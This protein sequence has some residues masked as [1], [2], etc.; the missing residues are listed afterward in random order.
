MGIFRPIFEPFP[1]STADHQPLPPIEEIDEIVTNFPDLAGLTEFVQDFQV[2]VLRGL[3]NVGI[4]V[5]DWQRDASFA[6]F[7][8]IERNIAVAEAQ[9][10][11]DALAA[12]VRIGGVGLDIESTIRE[13]EAKQLD[14]LD[15]DH[16][17][18]TNVIGSV[19]TSIQEDID[20]VSNGLLDFL[21]GLDRRLADS[22]TGL[23][24][25]TVELGNTLVTKIDAGLQETLGF[26]DDTV[27][28]PVAALLES[29]PVQV[30]SLSDAITGGLGGLLDIPEALLGGLGEIFDGLAQRLG[31]TE[32]LELFQFV[33]RIISQINKQF[34]DSTNL[35]VR[36]GSWDFQENAVNHM[37]A[38]L[39]SVPVIG[40]FYSTIHVGEFENIRQASFQWYRPSQ[41]DLGSIM[42]YMRR[43]P[44]DWDSVRSGLERAGLSDEKIGQ[45]ERIVYHPL[46]V[47]DVL[48]LWHRGELSPTGA[49]ERLQESG[50]SPQDIEFALILSDRIPPIQDQILFAVRGVFDVEESRRFGEFEGLP[51][52][53]EQRF[54]D[55]FGIEGGDFSRQVEVFAEQAAKTGL[56]EEWVAAYWTSHWQLPS[57]Q[58]AYEMFHRLAP[59]IVEA[60]SADIIADGFVPSEVSFDRES[61]NRLVRSADY[62]SYWRP[63]LSAIA[64]NPLTRVDI[65]RMHKLGTL[66]D[67]ATLRAYRKVG[68]SPT[69]AQRMLDFT[70]EFNK[71][72]EDQEQREVRELTRTQIL[73]F[74]EHFIFE[75]EEGVEALEDI[76]YTNFAAQSFVDIELTKRDRGL[77]R[78]SVDLVKE[79]VLA[80]LIDLNAASLE[81][82]GLEVGPGHKAKIIRELEIKLAR[83]TRQPSREDLDKFLGESII[84]PQEYRTAMGSLGYTDAWIERYLVLN[85]GA[86]NLGIPLALP[87]IEQVGEDFDNT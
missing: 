28:K 2:E 55:R 5:A 10:Q 39:G 16:G 24:A 13:L 80:G 35:D 43:N 34:D 84:S 18:I 68:F 70:I 17:D 41:L 63:K 75:P 83:R 36:A 15:R 31:L 3:D 82:D 56:P 42:E 73:D 52:D 60:E 85:L 46:P 51:A 62:S 26:I 9:R 21:G 11:A 65:R 59:D 38:L 76:G 22:I 71:E 8:A 79:E 7:E 37:N 27:A 44:T 20:G 25:D 47:L 49:R 74:V 50:L 30:A 81:L 57:L 33:A 14:R 45:L 87:P 77:Q 6:V 67:A 32:L 86:Q 64:Y 66:D 1:V 4:G 61:L 19:Q 12:A 29:L 78:D 48:S 40:S 69:D 54:I 72:P 23:A 53:I 58:A